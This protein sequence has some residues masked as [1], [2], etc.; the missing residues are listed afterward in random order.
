MANGVN[1]MKLEYK[2]ISPDDIELIISASNQ[3]FIL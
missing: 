3:G 2:G 1:G